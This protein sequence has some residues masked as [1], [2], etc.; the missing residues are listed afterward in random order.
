MPHSVLKIMMLA[1]CSDQLENLLRFTCE[2][3]Q[4]DCARSDA[5]ETLR[6]AHWKDT[7]A[8]GQRMANRQRLTGRSDAS[9]P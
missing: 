1:M 8:A 9:I 3:F 6:D 4:Q 5:E 7:A 2:H